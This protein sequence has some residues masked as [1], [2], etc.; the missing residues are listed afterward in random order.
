MT[1]LESLVKEYRETIE[2]F[3]RRYQKAGERVY[4]LENT[5]PFGIK[6]VKTSCSSFSPF[7]YAIILPDDY[8][9]LLPFYGLTSIKYDLVHEVSEGLADVKSNFVLPN[10]CK[11]AKFEDFNEVNWSNYLVN[12]GIEEGRAIVGA[13]RIILSLKE[14]SVLKEHEEGVAGLPSNWSIQCA[15]FFRS[16]MKLGYTGNVSTSD[17]YRTISR[18]LEPSN[19]VDEDLLII[20][21]FLESLHSPYGIRAYVLIQ[22]LDKKQFQRFT[23]KWEPR[24]FN[25][26]IKGINPVPYYFN[27]RV[28][29]DIPREHERIIEEEIKQWL[30]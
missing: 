5:T 3:V 8:E 18:P 1:E 9:R 20:K 2:K 22:K 14:R 26:K 15:E 24:D 30:K 25:E 29:F 16:I 27:Q 11:N 12:K 7:D 21:E 23:E 28:C 13:K 19:K 10:L 6:Y 4:G 17:L